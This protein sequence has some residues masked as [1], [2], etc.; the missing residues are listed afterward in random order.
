MLYLLLDA[1]EDTYALPS[2]E[3]EA[4]VPFALLKQVPGAPTSVAGILNYRG[5]QVAV[6]DCGTLLADKPC[7]AVSGSRII[8]CNTLIGGD[9]RRIGLLGERVV[10]THRFDK[11]DFKPVAARAET[12]EC[13]GPVATLDGALIQLLHPGKAIR[14]DVLKALLAGENE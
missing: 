1:G 2:G 10:S 6:M 11:S 7:S 12:P 3:I 8:I 4:V 9:Q 5:E 13:A 14:G